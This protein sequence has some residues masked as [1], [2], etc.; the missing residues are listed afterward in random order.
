MVIRA[1]KLAQDS[2]ISQLAAKVE[3]ASVQKSK[4]G[5]IVEKFAKSYTPAV[6]ASA[7]LLVIIPVILK[8]VAGMEGVG[9][10]KYWVYL[11]LVLLVC[12]CPCALVIST[13]VISVCGISRAAKQ[14][15][16]SGCIL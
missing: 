6:V 13:P 1:Q 5:H 2:T 4:A 11:A 15:S 14:V 8:K 16:F 7:A 3:E 9:D 12:A 10:L